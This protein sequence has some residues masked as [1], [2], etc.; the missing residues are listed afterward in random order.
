MQ[1]INQL[2]YKNWT[3]TVVFIEFSLHR[4]FL[5]EIFESFISGEIFTGKG[6]TTTITSISHFG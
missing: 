4:L 5:E 6:A 1:Q 3:Y 2:L